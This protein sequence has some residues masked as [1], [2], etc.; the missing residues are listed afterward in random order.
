MK[1]E[2]STYIVECPRDAMQGLHHMIST[3]QKINYLNLLLEVGFECIDFG[4]FVSPKAIPQMADTADVLRGLNTS[5]IKSDLLAIVANT[6]GIDEAVSHEA[7]THLGFPLSISETFQKRNTNAS[8]SE[9][10]KLVIYLVNECEN[11]GKKAVVYLSMCFGNPYGDAWSTDIVQLYVEKIM[12]LNVPIISLADT[13]GM[14][15]PGLI[16]SVLESVMPMRNDSVIGVHLHSSHDEADSKIAAAFDSGCRRF[17]TA[18]KGYGGCPMAKDDLV[19]NMATETLMSFLDK[20]GI[21]KKYNRLKF[22]Q[23]MEEAVSIMK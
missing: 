13:V 8:I 2:D 18:I 5:L 15:S 4:S 23:A 12:K 19:G 6:R 14:A 17:D 21:H 22:L 9:A 11:K 16:S 20:R 1:Q 7:I 10:L 3:D